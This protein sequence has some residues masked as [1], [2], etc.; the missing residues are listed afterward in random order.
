MSYTEVWYLTN[1]LYMETGS[2]IGIDEQDLE[3]KK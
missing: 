1:I 3:I 2:Y